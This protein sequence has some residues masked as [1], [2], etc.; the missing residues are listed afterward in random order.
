MRDGNGL[1]L[2]FSSLTLFLIT[3]GHQN[4]VVYGCSQLNGTDNDTGHEGK[5]DTLIE[6]NGHIHNDGELDNGYQ[7]HRQGD[8][9]E[10]DQDDSKDRCD[11]S[12]VYILKVDIRYI[13]QVFHQRSL[14]DDHSVA[15]VFLYNV[16]DLGDLGIYL[17]RR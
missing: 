15:V 5:A 7:D 3:A 4:C 1:F 11:G 6:G 16:T 8:G 10:D 14:T 13:L 17:V 12:D 2:I 9:F